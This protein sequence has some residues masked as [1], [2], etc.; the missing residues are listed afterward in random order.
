MNLGLLESQHRHGFGQ[1]EN[2]DV[3]FTQPL[4]FI[5]QSKSAD[6]L[7]NSDT[8]GDMPNDVLYRLLTMPVIPKAMANDVEEVLSSHQMTQNCPNLKPATD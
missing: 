3:L 1:T 2:F 6:G 7:V 5:D 4:T 8:I